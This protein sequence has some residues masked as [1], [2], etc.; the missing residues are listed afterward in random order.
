MIDEFSLLVKKIHN[1][2]REI[3][4]ELKN[5]NP[6]LKNLEKKVDNTKYKVTNTTSKLDI[7]LQKN[8]N[9]CLFSFI[10]VEIL[11]ILLILLS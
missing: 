6:Y 2:N 4:E 9:F 5:Q 11:I 1:S 8:S 7:Y 3:E 10:A